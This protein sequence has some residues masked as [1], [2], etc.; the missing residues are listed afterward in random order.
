MEA[1]DPSPFPSAGA[2]GEGAVSVKQLTPTTLSSPVS[3]RRTRSDWLA[4]KRDL[5]SSIASNAPPSE[6]TSSSSAHED[7]MSSSVFAAITGDPSKM[8][9]YSRRSDSNARICWMRNDH[10][11]SHGRGS[12]SASFHAGSWMARARARFDRVTP[13]ASRTMRGTL[14]SGCS[15][16]SPSELTCTP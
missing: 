1:A 8:S 16:V 11:W 12:P 14:F 5:S 13:R 9:P 7:S 6:R 4:T 10:C 3:M 2:S 15:S